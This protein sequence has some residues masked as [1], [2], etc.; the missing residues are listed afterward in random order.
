MDCWVMGMGRK[1]RSRCN[2]DMTRHDMLL[3][4]D[5]WIISAWTDGWMYRWIYGIQDGVRL[6]WR[7]RNTYLF[8]VVGPGG[9]G[10][11]VPNRMQ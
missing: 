5:W 4:G 2:D 9:P 10:F 7:G 8:V 1:W 6:R 11:E 3:C